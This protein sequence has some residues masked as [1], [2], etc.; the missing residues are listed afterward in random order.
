MKLRCTRNTSTMLPFT[1]GE[2]Y[3]AVDFSG[4]VY[5]IKGDDGREIIAPLNGHY[6][7]FLLA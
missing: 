7:T 2:V 5:Q 3:E 4:G 6:L 1:V